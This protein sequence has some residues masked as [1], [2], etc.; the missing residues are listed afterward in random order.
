MMKESDFR[1]CYR[2]ILVGNSETTRLA[3]LA[4]LASLHFSFI[5]YII[6]SR[7]SVK[8][9]FCAKHEIRRLPT[10]LCWQI[11]EMSNQF[12]REY[13][14]PHDFSGPWTLFP[15]F[16]D[17]SVP[18]YLQSCTDNVSPTNFLIT[19]FSSGTAKIDKKCIFFGATLD[20]KNRFSKQ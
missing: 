7:H 17:S 11:E 6:L 5:I 19:L 12:I 9:S 13:V 2:I 1:L 16:P 18:Q 14:Y 15:L 20:N 4:G 3:W 8:S 10:P